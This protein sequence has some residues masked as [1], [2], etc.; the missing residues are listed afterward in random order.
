MFDRDYRALVYTSLASATDHPQLRLPSSPF[1]LVIGADYADTEGSYF[2]SCKS[3]A[4]RY[5]IS[6]PIPGL[7]LQ[8]HKLHRPRY[9]PFCLHTSLDGPSPDANGREECVIYTMP[10]RVTS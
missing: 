7:V 5:E 6:Q 1:L 10:D 4:M 3:T 2:A 9:G 8:V